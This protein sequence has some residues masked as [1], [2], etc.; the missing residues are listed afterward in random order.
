MDHLFGAA[1]QFKPHGDVTDVTAWGRGNVHDTF[2]V[3]LDAGRER[4][5]I[6]QRVNTCVFRRPQLVT[7]NMRTVAAHVT[8]KLRRHPAAGRRWEVVR[9]LAARDGSD[10]WLAPDGSL[11]RALSWIDAAQ[12]FD[13]I[14]DE[15]HA[16]EIGTALGMFHSLIGDLPA[17]RLADT[18]AGF[19]VTPRYLEHFDEVLRHSPVPGSPELRYALAAVHR[20]RDRAHVLADALA[21]GVLQLRPIHGD[22]KVD[23]VMIDAAT[24]R[25]VAMVDL[26]TVMPGLVLYDIGDCLRSCCNLQGEESGDW[27]TAR[28]DSKLCR[29]ILR[30]YAAVAGDFLTDG[31]RGHL[32]DAV[33]L[34]A[35]ELGLRFVTD[36]L[37][38]NVY[39]KVR[40]SG[41]NL[42]RALRQFRLAASIESQEATLRTIIE[43]L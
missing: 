26:D 12:A 6:L 9:V 42:T 39:F 17:A 23:N 13:A 19:H 32:F 25:A 18:L 33:R 34:I 11:W 43:E 14:Q 40:H 2:R 24:R 29:V 31:D 21:R 36:H 16:H 20:G 35:Y 8:A 37:E 4:H 41:H 38:G 28:F 27:E 15:T 5:F 22:P 30:G 1:D 10:H 3:T 7:G